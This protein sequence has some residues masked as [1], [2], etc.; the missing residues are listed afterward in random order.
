M[1]YVRDGNLF[2]V[3]V[4]GGSLSVTQL[5]DVA[6]KKSEPRLTDT[7]RVAGLRIAGSRVRGSESG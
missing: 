3:P 2:I 1:T 7:V 4:Q 6:S 5:T